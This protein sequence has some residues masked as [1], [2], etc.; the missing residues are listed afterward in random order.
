MKEFKEF[1]CTVYELT[2]SYKVRKVIVTGTYNNW[3]STTGTSSRGLILAMNCHKT[4][5]AAVAAG[6]KK[7]ARRKAGLVAMIEKTDAQ[8]SNLEEQERNHK[9]PPKKAAKFPGKE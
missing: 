4:F 9:N 7:L 8:M 5:A 6:K 3:S 2:D 1:P